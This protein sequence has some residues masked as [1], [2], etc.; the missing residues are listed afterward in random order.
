MHVFEHTIMTRP[1]TNSKKWSV[2]LREYRE[3]MPIM[4]TG[5][6]ERSHVTVYKNA[7][8]IEQVKTFIDTHAIVVVSALGM[9][10]S[11]KALDMSKM[12][13]AAAKS[14]YDCSITG[15]RHIIAHLESY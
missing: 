4:L 11:V 5:D 12:L 3:V 9:S 7:E 1:R 14:N 2:K 8:S 6:K 10:S 15:K 13:E